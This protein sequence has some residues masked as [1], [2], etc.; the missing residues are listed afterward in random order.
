VRRLLLATGNPHKVEEVGAILGPD[1][2]V[3]ASDTGVDETG[4]T[5]EANAL[6]KAHAL[7]AASGELAVAD[8]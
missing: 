6:L 7:A 1:V 4:D 8:D 3:E 2:T 5:F